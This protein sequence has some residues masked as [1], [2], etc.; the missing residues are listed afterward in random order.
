MKNLIENKNLI[1]K[2]DLPPKVN[3][4]IN[5]AIELLDNDICTLNDLQNIVFLKDEIIKAEVNREKR[6]EKKSWIPYATNTTKP[7]TIKGVNRQIWTQ[8]EI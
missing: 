1:K 5:L 8:L 3:D 4:L 7:Y 6:M 2:E